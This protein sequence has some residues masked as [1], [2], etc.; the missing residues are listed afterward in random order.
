[1]SWISGN[2]FTYKLHKWHIQ[3]RIHWF[4]RQAPFTSVC[5]F[6]LKKATEKAN[7]TLKAI[8]SEMEWVNNA[9]FNILKF[10]L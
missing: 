2:D 7:K 5:F 4:L 6:F 1:M 8:Q 3:N 10:F 9:N